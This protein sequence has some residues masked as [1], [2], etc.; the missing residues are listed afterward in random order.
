MN[1]G[2]LLLIVLLC[3]DMFITYKNFNNILRI[4]LK[5]AAVVGIIFIAKELQ[6]S[7]LITTCLLFVESIIN[8]YIIKDNIENY[9]IGIKGSMLIYVVLN[10]F[11][12]FNTT[13]CFILLVCNIYLLIL[14]VLNRNKNNRIFN[15]ILILATMILS[16][17]YAD[18]SYIYDCI[19]L[20]IFYFDFY[21]LYTT[22]ENNKLYNV[23]FIALAIYTFANSI[24]L[25]SSKYIMLAIV[26]FALFIVITRK[27]KLIFCTSL[28]GYLLSSMYYFV[29]IFE[30]YK[31]VYILSV[32]MTLICTII[33]YKVILEKYHE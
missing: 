15:F 11:T 14:Y 13:K 10:Y 16:E 31:I 5:I 7:Y 25:L 6:L 3:L 22:S 8:K 32:I 12:F 28:F 27:N 23:L 33:L 24:L 2:Y 1:I 26:I 17:I 18:K 4:I 20:V 29:F 9:L 19:R 30:E 21:I